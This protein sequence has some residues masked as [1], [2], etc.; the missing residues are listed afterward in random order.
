MSPSPWAIIRLPAAR[1]TSH[2][3]RT[4]AS[5]TLAQSSGS[6]L[7]RHCDDIQARSDDKDVDAPAGVDH[8]LGVGRGFGPAIDGVCRVGFGGD[9]VELCEVARGQRQPGAHS[10]KSLRGGAAQGAGR[11]NYKCGLAAY[12]KSFNWAH[13]S[14]D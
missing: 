12:V 7:R 11:S 2:E 3:P 4:L 5:I 14:A 9:G 1:A 6:S 13:E 10:A 8:G